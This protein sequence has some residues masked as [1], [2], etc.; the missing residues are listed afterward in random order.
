MGNLSGGRRFP[1][2]KD[3]NSRFDYRVPTSVKGNHPSAWRNNAQKLRFPLGQRR[4]RKRKRISDQAE[5]AMQCFQTF[6]LNVFK[7]QEHSPVEVNTYVRTAGQVCL[8]SFEVPTLTLLR[9]SRC[10]HFKLLQEDPKDEEEER[11][12]CLFLLSLP[13]SISNTTSSRWCLPVP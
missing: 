2:K 3:I 12:L 13:A 1:K 9:I 4:E 11:E 5:N 8:N 6:V 7:Q 10:F